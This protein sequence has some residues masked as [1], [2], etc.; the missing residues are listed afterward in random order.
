MR[1][2]ERLILPQKRFYVKRTARLRLHN[3]ELYENHQFKI[4][5]RQGTIFLLHKVN[6]SLFKLITEIADGKWRRLS[7]RDK[8]TLLYTARSFS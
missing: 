4:I 2:F 5:R 7:T 6:H 8:L 1:Y 3:F